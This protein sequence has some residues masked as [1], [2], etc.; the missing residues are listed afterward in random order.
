MI[1]KLAIGIDIGGTK[2]NIGLVT[3][4]GELIELK[5]FATSALDP[6]QLKEDLIKELTNI[7]KSNKNISGIGLA[8]AGRINYNNKTVTYATDNLKDWARLPITDIL[9]K[10]FNL[11]VI[12][13]NDVNAALLCALKLNPALKKQIVIF[14]SIGTGLGGA[15]ALNGEIVRGTT[16]SA[17]EFGHMLLYPGGRQC[18]C[19][20]KG[21][22]EQYISGRAYKRILKEKF[23]TKNINFTNEDLTPEVI[24]NRIFQ[25]EK[26]Y[27]ETLTNLASNIALLLENIKNCIDFDTCILGG[28]F[29]V[30]QDIILKTISEKFNTYN[31]K[32]WQK[33]NFTFTKQGNNAGVIGGGLLVFE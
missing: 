23:Q 33:P 11:P 9:K 21:C 20:K 6:Q 30:Y 13:D 2:T 15:V 8:S 29:T 16:G 31:H 18:N 4:Q 5:S 25:G 7:L 26:I 1:M 10:Q 27:L 17:G 24:Q 14:L 28:S 12:I 19:G 3:P 32:Y 22:A